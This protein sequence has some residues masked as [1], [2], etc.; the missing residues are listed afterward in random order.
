ML[1]HDSFYVRKAKPGEP[2]GKTPLWFYLLIPLVFLVANPAV[3]MPQIWEYLNAYMGERLLVHTG[4]LF[5]NQLYKNNMS[6]SP[7]WGT[8]IYF[9]ALYTNALGA[10]K[11]GYFFPHDEF[12][13]D[14]LR[15]AIKF[16][17]DT[18]PQGA[19]MAH[20]TP[21]V[22]RHYL[23]RFARSDLGSHAISAADFDPAT[24]SGRAYIIVQRGRTY[25]EN[26]SK[27]EFV[28][29]NFKKVHEVSINGLTAVEVFANEGPYI[30][31]TLTVP[32]DHEVLSNL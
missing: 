23:E 18:A 22:A 13:D 30:S 27:L 11:A 6:S 2:S 8:P 9:Y 21:A 26:Q 32:H 4:Y 20:E 16:V 12:Y 15:E 10:N 5:G 17:C 3:L 14:G 28:R 31:P 25:F 19:I 7:F 24:L 1:Y 29:A